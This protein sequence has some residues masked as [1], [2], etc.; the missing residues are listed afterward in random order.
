MKSFLVPL[1]LLLLISCYLLNSTAAAAGQPRSARCTEMRGHMEEAWKKMLI[2]T[3]VTSSEPMFFET[4]QEFHVKYCDNF[5]KW[6]STMMQYEQCLR[7]YPKSIY[8]MVAKAARKSFKYI[9]S[10]DRSMEATVKHLRCFNP[11][12]R[13]QTRVVA[14]KFVHYFEVAVRMQDVDEV[15]PA[16]C[17]GAYDLMLQIKQDIM[18][19]CAPLTGKETA[20]FLADL[21]WRD[22]HDLLILG[23]RGP[24][25]WSSWTCDKEY[26][27]L[28]VYMKNELKR[29]AHYSNSFMT[30]LM[31][32]VRRLDK[33]R[34]LRTGRT[35]KRR[36]S[37]TTS[38]TTA[39]PGLE[40]R[41][42]FF[43]E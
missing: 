38:S 27:D 41:R 4:S 33:G 29:P 26:R 24:I 5:S 40:A 9:C 23:C 10:D 28:T 21:F 32:V 20:D 12:T 3:D 7:N 13:N 36:R 22:F 2:I 16:L 15:L 43:F 25:K 14:D 18:R 37:T 42:S 11:Q 30:S 19:I 34:N 31:R 1:P 8:H 17:C 35:F 6:M 39:A